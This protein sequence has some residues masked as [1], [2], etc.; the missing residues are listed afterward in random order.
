MF[1]AFSQAL[2]YVSNWQARKTTAMDG[3]C[4]GDSTGWRIRAGFRPSINSENNRL[5]TYAQRRRPAQTY[6]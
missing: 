5:L 2:A 1:E 3:S 6:S 4:R